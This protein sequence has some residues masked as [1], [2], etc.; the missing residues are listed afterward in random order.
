[1]LRK[2]AK[3]VEKITKEIKKTCEDMVQTMRT[4]KPK[5]VGLAAPQVGISLRIFVMEPEP[6][7][8]FCVINPQ[9]LMSNG[10][11]V[12]TE[13]CL[14]VPGVYYK[15]KRAEKILVTYFDV[16]TGKKEKREFEK[17]AARVFQHEFDHLNGVIF[18]DYCET[19]DELE[20]VENI[21][22]P[23]KLIERFKS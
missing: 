16:L 11:F 17:Y 2:T 20:F 23:P 12:D 6:G 19:V 22:I 10:T 13:G 5:G 18:T 15:V 8:L 14:S 9:I 21:K 7:N 4:N 3:S 1:M